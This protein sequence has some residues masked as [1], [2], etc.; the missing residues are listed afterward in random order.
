M[1]AEVRLSQSTP[2]QEQWSSASPVALALPPPAAAPAAGRVQSKSTLA[3]LLKEALSDNSAVPVVERPVQARRRNRRKRRGK[4]TFVREG[5]DGRR[6]EQEQHCCSDHETRRRRL[7]SLHSSSTLEA[8][9][10]GNR[11]ERVTFLDCKRVNEVAQP[12]WGRVVKQLAL[13]CRCLAA[14][15][16]AVGYVRG[17]REITACRRENGM[18][19]CP[20]LSPMR[21]HGRARATVMLMAATSAAATQFMQRR[22]RTYVY[23]YMHVEHIGIRR[24]VRTCV[25]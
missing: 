22:R 18:A 12:L 2:L 3:T 17:R 21:S 10:A 14:P 7:L 11:E 6:D 5:G 24:Y 9:Q 16:A 25:G 15:A 1:T 23:V 13:P 4:W 19:T 20:A 8:S